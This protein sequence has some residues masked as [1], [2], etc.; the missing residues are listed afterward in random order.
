[1]CS[2]L[3]K[4]LASLRF[5]TSAEGAEEPPGARP[6]TRAGDLV[7]QPILAADVKARPN[8]QEEYDPPGA[9][10]VVG[11]A[12]MRQQTTQ[13]KACPYGGDQRHPA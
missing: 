1:V 13:S 11:R 8:A 4:R 3:G 10:I 5:Y 7:E 2:Y 12:A 9:T 6:G